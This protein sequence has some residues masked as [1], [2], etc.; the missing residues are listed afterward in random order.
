MNAHAEK[1]NTNK[2]QSVANTISKKQHTSN[3]SFQFTDNRPEAVAQLKLQNMMTN[4]PKVSLTSQLQKNVT[5]TGKTIQL[6]NRLT[7][8]SAPKDTRLSG[9]GKGSSVNTG[10]EVSAVIAS[11]NLTDMKHSR[12]A[13]KRSIKVR[14]NSMNPDDKHA[15][16]IAQEKRWLARLNKAI[17]PLEA[18]S[19]EQ[20]RRMLMGRRP[21]PSAPPSNVRMP[22]N[23]GWGGIRAAAPAPAQQPIRFTPHEERHALGSLLD[24]INA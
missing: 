12:D 4:I 8:H 11:K 24:D 21:G 9:G 16:R 15:G 22:A 3:S 1:I 10:K 5:F 19:T 18:A 23:A 20:R 6:V 13:L 17:A 7:M 14:S 2:N